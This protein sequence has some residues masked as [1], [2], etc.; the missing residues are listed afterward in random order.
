MTGLSL[1][2]MLYYI[3]AKNTEFKNVMKENEGLLRDSSK[4]FEDHKSTLVSWGKKWGTVGASVITTMG[5][6]TKKSVN[7]NK[8]IAN[9]GTLIPGNVNR[10]KQ[11]K[12]E[13]QDTAITVGK[14]TTD[15]ARGAYQLVSAFGD[16]ADTT[17]KLTIN[18]KAAKAGL[19]ETTDAI[20][21]TS[22]VTKA[23][24]DISA[25]ATQK[26]ADLAF[27]T[28]KLGQ[29]TFPELAHSI[30]MVTP[31]AAQLNMEQEE[32]WNLFATLTGVTGDTAKVATQSAAILRAFLKQT[33][34][35][36]TAIEKLGYNSASAL[37]SDKG[38]VGALK[39]VIAQTDGS[40]EAIA[41]LFGRA[42][43]LT[44][45]FSL[46]GS[47]A[48]T[49]ARKLEQ[50]KNS[51]GASD[52]AFKEQTD[53][54][55][56]L[57]F[58]WERMQQKL[59]VGLERMGD[60]AADGIGVL[61]DG[62][63]IL[64][65]I[66]GK[67]ADGFNALPDPIRKTLSVVITLT[68]AVLALNVAFGV[69]KKTFSLFGM[70]GIITF[71]TNL[72]KALV[73]AKAGSAAAASAVTF[74][75][76]SF[77]SFLIGGVVLAGV[78]AIGAALY[79]I[80]QNAKLAKKEISEISDLQEALAKKK[81]IEEER[82]RIKRQLENRT[83]LEQ[84]AAAGDPYA[85]TTLEGGRIGGV[86]VKAAEDVE[87]LN[88]KL[89]DTEGQLNKIDSKIKEL[90]GETGGG[91][92][93]GGDDDGDGDGSGGVFNLTK[94]VTALEAE[95]NMVDK[96][97]A[98]FD[99]TSNVAADKASIL[100]NAI[101]ELVQEGVDPTNTS[102]GNLVELYKE[103]TQSAEDAKKKTFNLY[104]A[105]K[106]LFKALDAIDDKS[107][108]FGDEIDANGERLELFKDVILDALASG[109]DPMD[110]SI[111]DLIAEYKALKKEIDNTIKSTDLLKQA[112]SE[113]TDWQNR[114]LS[115][116][117]VLAQQLEAQAALDELNR[118]KLL[119]MADAMRKLAK[120]Q[121]EV[122]TAEKNNKE[123]TELLKQAQEEL[124]KMTGTAL[125]SWEKLAQKLEEM[126]SKDGVLPEVA[127]QLREMANLLRG[128]GAEAD[129]TNWFVDMFVDMGYEIEDARSIFEN[130]KDSTIDGFTNIITKGEKVGDVFKR[131]LDYLAEMIVKK[132]IIEPFVDWVLGGIGLGSAHVGAL[133]TPEG[134]IRDLPPYHTGGTVG[135]VPGLNSD[136][137]VIKVLTGERILSRSQNEKF[138]AGEYGKTEITNIFDIK[139]VDAAS[140]VQLVRSN[141]EAIT[142][143]VAGDIASDGHLRQV[144]KRYTK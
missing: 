136:E 8:E 99:D 138:E 18:A 48:D 12:R 117:E 130:F 92:G 36:S 89:A 66:I 2:N 135:A 20:N 119:E 144:I 87:T 42:E 93:G 115:T 95:L 7:M 59:A 112:Q 4:K 68:A 32:M 72:V 63:E 25:E 73:A 100:K 104:Q 3:K 58:Q 54:I 69:L 85:K 90:K 143:V 120:E 9:I 10:L 56:K 67:L 116:L 21:L 84:M 77:K 141:P 125:S 140:F 78:V 50:V 88:K 37:L 38:L 110:E 70:S 139:A 17:E 75:S 14:S 142:S 22:A 53:G 28:L 34:A 57:G 62:I 5:L 71:F 124:T 15:L 19:A 74:L 86:A 113:L 29:T 35:M 131:I 107:K 11:L 61:T 6:L 109:I 13:V 45:V 94:F 31:L 52:K 105:K 81:Q 46:T 103:Y 108:V 47:Q 43:A 128:A 96:I 1:G 55:N 16:T 97:A 118:D 65:D 137:R 44:A 80:Y 23:Y 39:A 64:V 30:G 123:A 102:M 111:Q 134:L 60:F 76:A 106:D 122:T 40:E 49:F 26:A 79:T 51:S 24:G 126:A 127:A 132:G 129:K 121:D 114:E 27:I 101:I 41:S 83:K 98:A 82:D 133:V 33:D 91:G